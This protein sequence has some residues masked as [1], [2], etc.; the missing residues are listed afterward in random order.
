LVGI[1]LCRGSVWAEDSYKIDSTK[2]EKKETQT[3]GQNVGQDPFAFATAEA[4]YKTGPEM[5]YDEAAGKLLETIQ[6]ILPDKYWDQEENGF[7]E[8]LVR[9]QPYRK[10]KEVQEAIRRW[11][12]A[13]FSLIAKG[14]EKSLPT[15]VTDGV[16]KMNPFN[17]SSLLE[18]NAFYLQGNFTAAAEKYRQIL[19]KN[20]DNPDSRNNLALCEMHLGH[21]LLAQFE[22]EV[23]RRIKADYLPAQINLSVVLERAGRTAEAEAMARAVAKQKGD[24]AIAA[25]NDSWFHSLAGRY[26]PAV[27]AL[28][29]FA[30]LAVNPK[31]K[32]FYAANVE[33][34]KGSGK[35]SSPKVTEAVRAK[36]PVDKAG[37]V[38]G[39]K[40]AK[41][42]QASQ[43]EKAAERPDR[44]QDK[45]GA[46]RLGSEEMFVKA[47]AFHQK[48]GGKDY[49]KAMEWYRKAADQG[50]A[51]AMNSIG[52]MYEHG[53]GVAGDPAQAAE[54]YGRAAKKGYA[55]AMHNLGVLYAQGKG[56]AKDAGIAVKWY[57]QAAGLG[58]TDAMNNLGVIYETGQGVVESKGGAA[59]WYRQAADKGHV[60]AMVNLARMYENGSGVAKDRS[61]ASNWY[62]KAAAKGSQVAKDAL[63]QLK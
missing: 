49:A 47:R 57:S 28:K 37:K 25:F 7:S 17:D 1:L 24:V 6:R 19:R 53:E 34:Q 15:L 40:P 33:L 54:W 39:K 16:S 23:L 14:P 5:A 2:E 48:S 32:D 63:R 55:P 30:E 51:A 41:E 50:H 21:D 12:E 29:P 59:K 42:I 20:P 35:A 13:N 4:M 52:S 10:T 26:E 62:E 43:E 8:L 61:Q 46:G 22:L 38:E 44:E 31:Y 45:D 36:E 56:V 27:A 18:A 3:E 9:L 60:A 11:A 58:D